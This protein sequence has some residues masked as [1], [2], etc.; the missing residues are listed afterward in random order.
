M[1]GKWWEADIDRRLRVSREFGHTVTCKSFL[2]NRE[3]DEPV[4]CTC[5]QDRAEESA[6]D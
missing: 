1:A 4:D 6:D 5:A 3:P 2:W